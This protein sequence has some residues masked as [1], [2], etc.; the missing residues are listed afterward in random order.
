VDAERW[1][2]RDEIAFFLGVDRRTITNYV[3]K[4]SDFPSRMKHGGRDREFPVRRC[5]QWKNDRAIAEVVASMGPKEPTGLEEAQ[6]RKAVAEAEMAEIK[7][8][9]MRGEVLD[10]GVI[11][12]EVRDVFARL[13]AALLSKPGE[14]APRLLNVRSMQEAVSL[15]RA[16]IDE[17]MVELQLSGSVVS[18][19]DDDDPDPAAGDVPGEAA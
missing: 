5:L 9:R 16:M 11:G 8:A 13:R 1:V 3:K 19:M 15:L 2:D 4:H 6:A 18:D 17:C 12:R 14:H 7:V 10:V